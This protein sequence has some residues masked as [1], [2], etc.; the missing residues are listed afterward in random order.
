MKL[1]LQIYS[2]RGHLGDNEIRE[3]LSRIRAMGYEGIEWPGLMGYTPAALADLTREAGLTFF[4]VHINIDDL[5]ACDLSLLDE[6]AAAGTKYLPIGWLPEE[7]LAG[8]ALFEETCALIRRY[9]AEAAAR[10]MMVMYHNHDF[11]LARLEDGTPRLDALY[12]A[13]SGDVLGAELDTCWLYSGKVDP[14]DY[15]RKYAN[16][17]PVIHLKDCTAGGGREGFRPVGR[18][19]LDWDGILAAAKEADTPWVCVEQD[20]PSEGMDDFRCVELS[21][22]FL[23]KSL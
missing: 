3:T 4:S 15:L 13:L 21:A 11:D 8:G 17:A 14:A 19:V 5:T 9:S 2:L 20:D 22:D 6:L 12:A 23:K 1:A 18:G 16:R 10:G 7:R